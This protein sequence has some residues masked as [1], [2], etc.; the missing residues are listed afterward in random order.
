MYVS[1]RF[2]W[3]GGKMWSIN[4]TQSLTSSLSSSKNRCRDN[5]VWHWG[6]HCCKDSH[7][8]LAVHFVPYDHPLR[9]RDTCKRPRWYGERWAVSWK[10]ICLRHW[11]AGMVCMSWAPDRLLREAPLP[12]LPHFYMFNQVFPLSV[13]LGQ[14]PY[15]KNQFCLGRGFFLEGHLVSPCL[16][17]F[18]Y[19]FLLL[20]LCLS[21]G[22]GS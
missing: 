4:F 2:A 14:Q 21:Q 9:W 10:P 13:C 1:L 8:V 19:P 5:H 20:S 7:C 18:I 17:K 3:T 6:G 16:V 15:A 12:P 11:N 22:K